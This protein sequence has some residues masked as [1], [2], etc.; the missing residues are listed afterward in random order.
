MGGRLLFFL[1]LSSN[2]AFDVILGLSINVGSH[3]TANKTLSGPL[4][5]QD[6]ELVVY[7]EISTDIP[8]ESG[9]ETNRALGHTFVS[10]GLI[11]SL[12][13]I[14]STWSK[15][16]SFGTDSWRPEE[17]YWVMHLHCSVFTCTGSVNIGE[18][19]GIVEMDV[20]TGLL[21]KTVSI[22]DPQTEPIQTL[23]DAT[24]SIPTTSIATASYS[25]LVS[26]QS[27]CSPDVVV[28]ATISDDSSVH[29]GLSYKGLQ[30][31]SVDWFD[32]T[33]ILCGNSSSQD[34][35][36]GSLIDLK[37]TSEHLIILT[38]E[39]IF[40]IHLKGQGLNKNLVNTVSVD[41]ILEDI[42][43]NNTRLSYTTT[44]NPERLVDEVVLLVKQLPYPDTLPRAQG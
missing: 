38:S 40:T 24:S 12:T 26:S 41:I 43:P 11:P 19:Y 21:R 27:P 44:C 15:T 28:M 31:D 20:H 42:L 39:A 6:Q 34:C 29:M 35:D 36:L 37:L 22:V 25:R 18:W 2:F 5:I 10:L 4:I 32:L 1:V 30:P 9:S 7:Y 13:I 3:W 17:G 23:C 14:N 16:F 33:D 8:D